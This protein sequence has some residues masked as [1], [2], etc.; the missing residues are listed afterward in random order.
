MYYNKRTINDDQLMNDFE[1]RYGR[2]FEIGW[3]Q[4]CIAQRIVSG[5][6]W[7]AICNSACVITWPV[8]AFDL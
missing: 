7:Y 2:Y 4:K 1:R 3:R 8:L 5:N 6:V